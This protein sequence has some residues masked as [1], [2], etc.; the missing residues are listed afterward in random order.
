MTTEDQFND[1]AKRVTVY[2]RSLKDLERKHEIPGKGFYSAKLAIQ[3]SR[4][5]AFIMIYN[6][7]EFGLRSA[8]QDV[9]QAIA[10]GGYGFGEL[11]D[12]WRVDLT[13]QRHAKRLQ[14]GVNHDEFLNLIALE[15]R[16][17]SAW[18][19][20]LDKVPFPG[21]ID[22][23]KILKFVGK[24]GVN[25]SPPPTSLG[26]SD[27]DLVKRTRNDLAHGHERFED[28]GANYSTQ[29]ILDKF[30]RIRKFMISAI[31][32]IKRHEN[33]QLYLN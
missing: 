6:C 11:S 24:L 12:Y 20:G 26:G 4:A 2:L 7:V 21:N 18:P 17:T 23:R 25:W 30:I 13:R 27:L 14:A 31:R 1:R 29:D 3:A 22:N 33:R 19:E 5:S 10:A 9:R 16:V 8:A 28:V 15:E 32:A